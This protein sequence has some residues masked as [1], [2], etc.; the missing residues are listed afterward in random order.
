MVG[1]PLLRQRPPIL[2]VSAGTSEHGLTT[3]MSTHHILEFIS[4]RIK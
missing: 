3:G 4:D 2:E 1:T